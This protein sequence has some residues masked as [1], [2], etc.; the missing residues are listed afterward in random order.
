MG[1][2]KPNN[3]FLKAQSTIGSRGE[4]ILEAAP[5]FGLQCYVVFLSLTPLGWIKWISIT[6]SVLTLSLT[7]IEHY[8]TAREVKLMTKM[9]REPKNTDFKGLNDLELKTIDTFGPMS[10]LKNIA[11]FLPQSLF[12]ILAVSIL[13]V[14]FN[15][16]ASSIVSFH[17]L[18]LVVCLAITKRHYNLRGKAWDRQLWECL[19]L[20]WLTISNLGRGKAAAVCRLVSSLFWTIAHTINITIILAICNID[21]GIFDAEDRNL[22]VVWSELALVQN[23]STLN[24]LLISTLCLGWASLALDVITAHVKHHYRSSDN[25]EEQEEEN[26]FWDRAI[27]LEGWKY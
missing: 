10:I 26:S 3:Q 25:T 24:A 12:K 1:L 6:T 19:P 14:F 17:V 7:N 27:L 4:S 8:V 9:P 11:I 23:L 18:V 21:P 13:G 15:F 16:A 22:E 20:S 2:V 5:Q